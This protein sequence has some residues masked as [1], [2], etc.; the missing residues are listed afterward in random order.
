MLFRMIYNFY[1]MHIEK[2]STK[3]Y[4]LNESH[5]I[6]Y[7]LNYADKIESQKRKVL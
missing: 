5:G 6:A 3:N 4:T 2:V 7:A 1:N